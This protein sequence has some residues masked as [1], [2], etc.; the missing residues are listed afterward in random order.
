[1]GTYKLMTRLWP[2]PRD[3]DIAILG[4]FV[5]FYVT[6]LDKLGSRTIFLYCKVIK[7]EFVLFACRLVS[8]LFHAFMGFLYEAARL[9]LVKPVLPFT[10]VENYSLML[11][12]YL[13]VDSTAF[14]G[15]PVRVANY[16]PSA[17]AFTAVRPDWSR[18]VPEGESL[19]SSST[20]W[21]ATAFCTSN[22]ARGAAEG[23]SVHRFSE[24]SEKFRALR[25]LNPLF[26]YD[27]KVGNY[28]SKGDA[29][30]MAFLFPT[31]GDLTGGIRKSP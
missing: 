15:L 22:S 12:L 26:R 29:S 4:G 7:G 21:E 3:P 20:G 5:E 23:G 1:M 31:I 30:T 19:P 9:A 16:V 8:G 25:A 17:S 18:P 28:F 11:S 24:K 13:K 6:G 27:Y 2:A 14:A 10:F